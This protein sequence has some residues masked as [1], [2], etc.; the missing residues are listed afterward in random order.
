V[1]RSIVAQCGHQRPQRIGEGDALPP[2]PPTGTNV[3]GYL[4]L[5]VLGTAVAYALWFRGIRALPATDVTFLGLLSPV[6]ATVAGWAVAGQ[7]LTGG[8]LLGVAVVLGALIA[9]Q[10]AGRRT[11]GS[12]PAVPARGSA[13]ACGS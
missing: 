11:A 3:A 6:V 12:G 4:Y 9:G 1:L 13:A 7:A 5:G 2:T 10:T 8:Q